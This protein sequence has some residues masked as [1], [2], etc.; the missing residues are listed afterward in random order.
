MPSA[1]A[2]MA[3]ALT[4]APGIRGI[5][6]IYEHHPL[7]NKFHT[8]MVILHP[9]TGQDELSCH[10][11]VA[12][13]S[14]KT[15]KYIALSY[16]WGN[17]RKVVKMSCD[18]QPISITA[19]LADALLA[20]RHPQHSQRIWA[21]AISINQ[22]DEAEKSQQVK[23]MGVVYSTAE[24][25][26][27]WVGHDVDLIA[28]DCFAVIR[29]TNHYLGGELTRCGDTT[30]IPTLVRPYPIISDRKRWDK[31]RQLLAQPWFRRVWVIQEAG[32][33]RSCNMR[34]GEHEIE[35]AHVVELALWHVLREDFAEV[36]GPLNALR[37]TDVF[38]DI[39][40]NYE[41]K[42][43]WRTSLPLLRAE[44]GLCSNKTQI[45][46]DILLAASGL[47]ASD[48]RDYI[49]AFLS[50]SHALYP[51]GKLLLDP[52]YS[53]DLS[54]IFYETACAVLRHPKEA[55]FL[56]SRVKHLSEESLT[57]LKF[58]SWLPRWDKVI[59]Y[60]I[61]RPKFWY[62]AGG[63]EDF[64]PVVHLDRS[65]STRGVIFDKIVYTSQNITRNNVSKDPADWDEEFR[66][67]RKPFI[68]VLWEET[69][70]AAKPVSISAFESDFAW[71]IVRGYP[72]TP[73]KISE[74]Q[75]M[76]ELAAYRHLVRQACGSDALK[77]DNFEVGPGDARFP[78]N[79]L[80]RLNYC[81]KLRVALTESGR[82]GLV[83]HVSHP[84]DI[85][86]IM[87][88]VP[89]PMILRPRKDGMFTF[90]G[91]SYVQGAMAGEVLQDV[92]RGKLRME[93][94]TLL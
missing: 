15:Q 29:D 25:V 81:D 23:R 59:D 70:V 87:P 88:G 76:D 79:F 65:L 64:A 67:A 74:A 82:L 43:T 37:L 93:T 51:E 35:F 3:P 34:W 6:D 90:V 62:S 83:P 24:H 80:H 17:P 73:G 45:F 20:L 12:R 33:A 28:E 26:V 36:A 19:N 66:T 11:V 61:S 53:K 91:E 52:D 31:V 18:G 42:E 27:I 84:D 49:F 47:L 21:D 44:V 41:N 54:D 94:I 63:L 48:P 71:T 60:T 30:D 9:G 86:C 77:E 46:L 68:D 40:L 7:P 16:V 32:L 4:E 78:R 39:H 14:P 58:P 1:S 13:P 57:D 55:P 50:N 75:Q 56:L 92:A 5:P 89:V 10:L 8:R 69:L 22:A 38:R 85:C 2:P 72:A